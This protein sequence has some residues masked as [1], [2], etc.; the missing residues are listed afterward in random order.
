MSPADAP[1]TRERILTAAEDVIRRF[2]P[3]KATVTDV[4]R[5]LGVSH[6]A[7]YRHI[8]TKAELRDAVVGRCA[9]ARMPALRALV[10]ASEP[11]PQRLRQFFDELVSSKRKWA[12]QDPE[13]FTAYRTLSAEAKT[14]SNAHV[15]DLV[16]L[17]AAIVQQG[18]DDGTFRTLD[19]V[20]AARAVLNATLR[21]HHPTH[22]GEW[23]DPTIDTAYND[24]WQ[25]LMTGLVPTSSRA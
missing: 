8:A 3:E 20:S 5:A 6:A 13:L 9:E 25:L 18:V 10:D 21:F 15:D 2:G 1:L 22:A 4:A 17:A 19:A 11:A 14:A 24:V 7:L 12:A 23:N 16:K